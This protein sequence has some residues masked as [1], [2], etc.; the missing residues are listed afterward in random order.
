[1]KTAIKL[2]FEVPDQK[3]AENLEAIL[4]RYANN[5]VPADIDGQPVEFRGSD[6]EEVEE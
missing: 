3:T 5:D 4:R 6:V 1:M 2:Y